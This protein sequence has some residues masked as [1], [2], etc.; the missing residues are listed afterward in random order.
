M[1]DNYIVKLDKKKFESQKDNIVLDA[2]TIKVLNPKDREIG[3]P[4]TTAFG[5]KLSNN[6]NFLLRM[7]LLNFLEQYK[8]V[9]QNI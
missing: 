3:E 5:E 9:I 6:R 1:N 7:V 4:I 2:E 8:M